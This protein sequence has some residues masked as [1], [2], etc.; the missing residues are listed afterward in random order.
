MGADTAIT[1]KTQIPPGLRPWK[2]GQSGNPSGRPK[3]KPITDALLAAVDPKAF[4]EKLVS[5]AM[6]GDIRAISEVLDRIEGKAQQSIE[7]SGDVASALVESIRARRN[8]HEAP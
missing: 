7:H 6:R 4:A 8:G 2:P 1:A 3:S 5:L